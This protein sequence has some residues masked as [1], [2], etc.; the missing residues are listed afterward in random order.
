MTDRRTLTNTES[1]SADVDRFLQEVARAPAA[2]TAGRGRLIFALDATASRQPTWDRACDVQAQMFVETDRLGGLDV[3]LVYYRG[4]GECRA[5]KWVSRPADLVRLMTGVTCM[6][7]KTQ[8][9]RILSHAIRETRKKQVSALVFVGDCFEEDV[10]RV[11]HLAG[12]VGMLG[13]RAFVFHEGRDRGAEH[14]LRQITT[15]TKG[16]FC[17]LDSTSPQQLRELLGAVAAYAAG[18]R[19]ALKALAGKGNRTVALL[20]S[21][22]SGS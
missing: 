4:F 9:G 1:G 3:Q 22:L 19:A 18:G 10:D 16:A 14:A 17:P 21:Q 15:L 7:G 2:A 13:V 20:E 8:V 6:A 5:S 12:Q 11:G